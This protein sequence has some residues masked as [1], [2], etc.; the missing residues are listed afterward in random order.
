[1]FQRQ[2]TQRCKIVEF[3]NI[4]FFIEFSHIVSFVAEL[5]KYEKNTNLLIFFSKKH[6]NYFRLKKFA[7]G[8]KIKNFNFGLLSKK[9]L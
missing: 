8:K 9:I 2:H 1:M 5:F 4:L 3:S 7:K 6:S